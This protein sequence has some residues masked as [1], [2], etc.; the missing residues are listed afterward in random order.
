MQDLSLFFTMTTHVNKQLVDR[1]EIHTHTHTHTHV[2]MAIA[3]IQTPKASCSF[4]MHNA[5]QSISFLEN[6][7][8][9]LN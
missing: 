4:T 1:H 6:C 5:F 7:R 3:K 9:P 2:R 8:D